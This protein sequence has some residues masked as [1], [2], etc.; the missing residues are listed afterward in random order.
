MQIKEI[1][2]LHHSHFDV[3][4]THSQPIV[5]QLQ[6]EFIE[7]ALQLLDVTSDWD[8]NSKPRWTCE[9][10]AQVI[11]WLEFANESS[12]EKFKKYVSEK[13]IGISGLE[14]NTTP[15]SN[16]EQITL[17]LKNIKKLK[18]MFGAEIKTVNQHDVNGI[19]WGAADIMIDAGIELFIMATNNHFGGYTY[20]RPS[21]FKWETP[22]KR[23]LLVMNGAHYTMFDQLLDTHENN[24]VKMEEGYKKYLDHLG[25][26]EYDLD[27]IYLTTAN[28][29]VCYDNAPPNIDV[30][31]LIRAW[32]EKGKQP[33]IRYITPNMLLERIKKVETK[34]IAKLKGDWTDY[35]NYGCASTAY[36][37]KVNQNT[38]ALLH[39][40]EMISTV[41]KKQNQ[42]RRK[43]V[44]DQARYNI[45]LY[46][47]H[48]WGAFNSVDYDNE[49]VR[50]QD[51]LKKQLAFNG[52]EATEYYLVNELENLT[53]NP[54]SNFKQEGVL[55]VNSSAAKKKA[56]IPIP[57]WW[58]LDGKRLRTARF[59]YPNRYQQLEEAPLYGPIE[60]EPFSWQKIPFTKLKP[61]K[62]TKLLK[63]G[64]NIKKTKVQRLNRQE[65]QTE[66]SGLSF[67]ESP[68]HRLEY[69][70]KNGRIISLFDK[71]QKWE[72]L[73]QSS[74][75][76]F[77]Q[78]V[79]EYPDPLIDKDR[80]AMYARNLTMEKYDAN[81]WMT[82]WRA[83]RETAA[84]FIETKILESPNSKTLILKFNVAG[85]KYLEQKITLQAD[86]PIIKLDLSIQK[87]DI[88]TPE[89]IYFAFPLN[90]NKNWKGSFDTC[91]THVLLDEKQLPRSSK[92]WQTVESYGAIYNKEN[93][94]ALFCPDAPM[95]QM[96]GFNFGRKFSEIKRNANPLLLAWTLNN[97]WDTNFSSSQPGLINISYG[98]MTFKNFEKQKMFEQ[99]RGLAVNLE[100]HPLM[101]CS[102]LTKGS[103]I[104]YDDK[105]VEIL[106][107]KL[108]EDEN[109][110]IV[111]VVKTLSDKKSVAFKFP[112]DILSANEV[113]TLE[114]EIKKLKFKAK[115]ITMDLIKNKITQFCIEYKI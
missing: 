30:A 20:K 29:P 66:E 18:E 103:F 75:Y 105:N 49:F 31:K 109:K 111:R 48:T 92:G 83:K 99:G 50:S 79:R 106:N 27:F 107:V 14:F 85:A 26:I 47:E 67:I 68:F 46:D 25:K 61:A 69:D 1:L 15:N 11:K 88:R 98:F 72:V 2:L 90:I 87:E 114:N 6:Y 97:Y 108:A 112:F 82:E 86:S 34:K 23:E 54:E 42:F 89:S 53:E 100:V 62:P 13:R 64:D 80:S 38:K 115:T 94:A 101:N 43:E 102:K 3:G 58:K 9:V 7:Q 19:P 4:Y 5:W 57:D 96:G 40:A 39:T 104:K 10:T 12:I 28:A 70:K 22:S 52:R 41:A 8:E 44:L 63:A 81:C 56:Y 77:F 91:A 60:I 16:A 21:V 24:M 51:N 37:T 74:E 110:V 95:I 84:D 55:I 36:E 32:N 73:D 17:Q 35:W 76:T 45:N 65:G 59:G 113:D 78:F 33:L 71:T 93:G